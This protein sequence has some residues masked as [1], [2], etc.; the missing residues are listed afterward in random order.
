MKKIDQRNYFVVIDDSEEMWTAVKFATKRAK[1]TKSNLTT[2]SFIESFSDGMMLTPSTEKILDKEQVSSEK[3]KHKE[4]QD[5]IFK[6]SKIKAKSEIFKI[7]EIDDFINFLN[8]YSSNSTIVLATSK[9]I[10]KPGP[11]IDKL[12]YE[13]GNSLHCPLVIINGNLED[14]EIEKII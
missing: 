1:T 2:I 10:G 6:T 13:K 8:S 3:I 5:F 4:V 11:L 12:I 7:S 9:D 14:K